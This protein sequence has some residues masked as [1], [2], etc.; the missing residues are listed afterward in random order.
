VHPAGGDGTYAFAATAGEGATEVKATG[1][2]QPDDLRLD[3]EKLVASVSLASGQNTDV[4]PA[5]VR[6]VID[7]YHLGGTFDVQGTARVPL[8]RISESSY[9]ATLQVSDGAGVLARSDTLIDKVHLA[10]AID[11]APMP[12]DADLTEGSRPRPPPTRPATKPSTQPPARFPPLHVRLLPCGGR[13]GESTLALDEGEFWL[14]PTRRAWKLVHFAGLL[15]GLEDLGS[16]GHNVQL[17]RIVDRLQLRGQLAF[18]AAASGPTVIP[19]G[20]TAKDLVRYEVLAFPDKF[21]FRPRRWPLPIEG[22]SGGSIRAEKGVVHLT[23]LAAQ[24]GGDRL[25]LKSA[26]IPLPEAISDLWALE[27]HLEDIDG[28]LT[29]FRPNPP[30][31]GGLADK[32]A[33]LRP[34]GT[35]RLGGRYTINHHRDYLD[36]YSMDIFADGQPSFAATERRLPLTRL[37]GRATV[38]PMG[39]RIFRTEAQAFG[40]VLTAESRI[41]PGRPTLYEGRAWVRGID[42]AAFSRAMELGGGQIVRKVGGRGSLDFLF[43]IE[44]GRRRDGSPVTAL[45]TFRGQGE[46]QVVRAHFWEDP[47]VKRI[48]SDVGGRSR[49][50]AREGEGVG[51]AA[52]VFSV[53]DRYVTLRSAAVS[54]PMVG[55]QGSGRI[56]FDGRVDLQVYAAPLGDLRDKMRQTG[57]PLVGDVGAEVVGAVQ[58]ILRGATGALLYQYRVTGPARDPRYEVVPVP[59]L[60]DGVAALFGEMARSGENENDRLLKAVKAREAREARERAQ[61]PGRSQLTP[62][63]GKQ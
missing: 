49:T 59:V 37:L 48:A 15:R 6:G 57:I 46:V 4:L 16:E 1:R 24:Y 18:T 14:D 27:T 53:A 11:S 56:G 36:D 34:E 17:E 30:Y 50:A 42:V 62:P 8:R 5:P 9:E 10:I 35:F 2:L 38:S 7:R 51:D 47:I 61:K 23:A 19:P 39:T 54:S 26:R 25:L 44:S 41:T 28:T 20:Q 31:P 55:L 29:C 13:C 40:G 45:D 12:A 60:T 52:A 21:A 58:Q 63:A 33:L 3:L 43:E 22:I 32:V